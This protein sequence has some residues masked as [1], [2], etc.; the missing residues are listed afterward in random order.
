MSRIAVY[1]MQLSPN[2]IA[3]HVKFRIPTALKLSPRGQ[4]ANRKLTMPHITEHGVEVVD[5][6]PTGAHAI[7][8]GDDS[9]PGT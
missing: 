1:G 9:R 4:V 7:A 8:S 5:D 3:L 2:V 6:T